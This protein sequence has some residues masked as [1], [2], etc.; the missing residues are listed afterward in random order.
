MIYKSLIEYNKTFDKDDKHYNHALLLTN[1]EIE[2]LRTFIGMSHNMGCSAV[3]WNSTETE[4]VAQHIHDTLH[5]YG[6]EHW[7]CMHYES[8]R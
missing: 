2:F 7:D 3:Q 8:D 5:V 6:I 4:E 1:K